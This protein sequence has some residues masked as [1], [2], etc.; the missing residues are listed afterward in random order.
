MSTVNYGAV[1]VAVCAAFVTSA[2][3][4]IVFARQRAA[5]SPA[6]RASGRPKPGVMVVELVRSTILAAVLDY[7]L[8]H[9]GTTTFWGALWL[10]LL[11]WLAFPFILLTGSVMYEKLPWKLAMIHAGDWA[12]KL[13]LMAGIVAVWR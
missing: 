8:Q 6:A 13:V 3:Y 4:Y 10:S 11:L 7:L 9:T 2:I 12:I 5:L 1:L